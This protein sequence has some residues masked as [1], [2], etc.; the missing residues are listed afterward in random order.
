MKKIKILTITA[1]FLIFLSSCTSLI[2]SKAGLNEASPKLEKIS[3]PDKEVYFLGM[4]HLQKN[5][6]YENAKK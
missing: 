4:A 1:S 6:F 2:A 3:V 5:D